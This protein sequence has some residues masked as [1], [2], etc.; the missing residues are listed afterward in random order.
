MPPIERDLRARLLEAAR[1]YP[2]LFLGGCRQAGK[3]TLLRATFPDHRFVTLDIPSVAEQAETRPEDLLAGNEPLLLDEIQYAPALPRALKVAI[4][5]G[6]AP[7]G[8]FVLAGSQVFQAMS[9]ISESLA[10]RCAVLQLDT[11]GV[12]ELATANLL[13]DRDPLALI[14]RGGYP[15]PW[16]EPDL[17][18]ELFFSSYLATYLERDV[19]NLLR[20]A[21]LRDFERF[22]RALA[23]RTGQLLSYSELSREVGV[24]VNT[25]KEWTSVLVTSGVVTLLEPFHRS[26]GKRLVKSPKVYWNDAGFAAWLCGIHGREQ[27][28]ASPLCGALWETLVHGELRRRLALAAPGTPLWFWNVQGGAEVDFLIDDGGRYRLFEAKLATTASGPKDLRGFKAFARVYGEEA[29]SQATVVCRAEAVH[30]TDGGCR[31]VGLRDL[32]LA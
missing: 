29:V 10:G 9:G 7:P 2:A 8:R 23:I 30:E 19:R 14:T 25:I 26:L 27:L 4:D 13:D 32:V 16:A 18:R 6:D 20:V 24:A 3:T 21:N 12:H 17:P 5:R 11:L 22:V 1:F 28:L 31:V 15:R